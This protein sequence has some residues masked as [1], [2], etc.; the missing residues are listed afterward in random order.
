MKIEIFD[1]ESIAQNLNALGVSAVF[2]KAVTNCTTTKYHFNLQDIRDLSK[3][4]K[5]T[6]L[7]SAFSHIEIKNCNS[8]IA[9]FCL[10]IANKER[11]YPVYNQTW[12]NI[13]N[14]KT[15]AIAF[16]FDENMEILV[17]EIEKLPHILVSG[18]TNSGKSVFLNNIILNIHNHKDPTRLVLIDPKEVE[19]CKYENSNRLVLPI[20][21]SVSEAIVA[22]KALCEEMD[23]RYSQL[24]KCGLKNNDTG[25][26]EKIVCIVDELAD[27][28]LTSKKAVENYIVRLAQKG[29]TCGIHLVLA[30]QRPTVNVVTG[31]IK[32]NIP[33]RVAFVSSSMRD[34]MV[35]LDYKGAEQLLGNGDCLV[36][37]PDQLI[38][39][40][41]QTPFVSQQDIDAVLPDEPRKW[42]NKNILKAQ[43]LRKST[44]LDKLLG[45]NK[46]RQNS[47]QKDT[48]S[49]SVSSKNNPITLNE[50][51]DYETFDDDDED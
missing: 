10:V 41:I 7:L 21:T 18:A 39:I 25:K 6:K 43:K 12:W 35:M 11:Y 48:I 26:F 23:R 8:D 47:K 32:A 22:L 31:L 50:I 4:K 9:H 17:R 5:A 40:R 45:L 42:K 13:E 46:K 3:L 34:S 37:L 49:S 38:P 27:L 30:T 1:G 24:R 16:G 44:W 20:A 36:K 28:M 2:V 51:M 14:R 19:F 15:S 29:R 33:C